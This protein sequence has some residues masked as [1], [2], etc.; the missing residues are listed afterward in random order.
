MLSNSANSESAS[1]PGGRVERHRKPGGPAIPGA[2]S[3]CVA[4]LILKAGDHYTWTPDGIVLLKSGHLA[5]SYYIGNQPNP[6][7]TLAAVICELLTSP[8]IRGLTF[9][10]VSRPASMMRYLQGKAAKS[11]PNKFFQLLREFLSGSDPLIAQRAARVLVKIHESVGPVLDFEMFLEC[12]LRVD[13]VTLAKCSQIL[14]AAL[15][16]IPDPLLIE[17]RC[18]EFRQTLAATR[19]RLRPHLGRLHSDRTSNERSFDAALREVEEKLW[20]HEVRHRYAAGDRSVP[21]TEVR[22]LIRSE[23]SA[24]KIKLT[25]QENPT[26]KFDFRDEAD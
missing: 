17:A 7:A 5:M 3:Y 9:E 8:E 6:G 4:G 14:N 16:V 11:L 12:F 2:Q 26:I 23:T 24:R 18:G 21:K 22:R 20:R 13:T 19:M 1:V 15:K 25:V 10:D